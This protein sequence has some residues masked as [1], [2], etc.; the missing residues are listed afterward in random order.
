MKYSHCLLT[1][2]LVSSTLHLAF[3]QLTVTYPIENSVFQRDLNNQATVYVAGY[4]SQALDAVEVKFTPIRQGWGQESNWMTLQGGLQKGHFS[5]NIGWSGGW[6]RLDLRGKSGGNV[7]GSAVVN[8]V[9]VGEVFLIA[10]QSNGQGRVGYGAQPASDERVIHADYDGTSG[11]NQPFPYPSFSTLQADDVISPR[12]KSS[13]LWGKLGDALSSRLNVPILFYNTAWDG[14]AVRAWKESINGIGWSVYDPSLSFEPA[15]MPYGNLRQVM[16]NYV[17]IT[18]LRA[19]LW[20]QGEAD[21]DVGTS[22]GSY[23][24]DLETLINQTRNEF[25]RNISWVIARESYTGRAGIGAAIV[26]A[27]NQII[28]NMGNIFPGPELDKVQVPRPDGYHFSDGGLLTAASEWNN[29]LSSDFFSRSVPYPS[30]APISVFTTC[31]HNSITIHTEGAYRDFKWNT[32]SNNS[33]LNAGEGVYQVSAYDAEGNYRFSPKVRIP[34]ASELSIEQPTVTSVGKAEVCLGGSLTLVSSSDRNPVWSTG[35]TGK[36]V[37]ISAPGNYQV[38]IEN[39]Y[40]C[41]TTSADFTV[42]KS[43]KTLPAPPVVTAD[44]ATE[45]CAGEE[46]TL[47]SNTGNNTF[48]SNGVNN[49]SATKVGSN[50]QFFARTRDSEGCF[51]ENSNSIAVKVNALPAKPTISTD[52]TPEFCDGEE[53]TLKSSYEQGNTWSDNST[54]QQVVIKK[55]G[56]YKVSV[57][58]AKGCKNT[59]DALRVTVNA[60]PATPT[61]TSLRPTTFCQGDYSTLSATAED[62][63]IWNT[64]SNNRQINVNQNGDY[65]VQTK[66]DKGCFSKNSNIIS[67]TVNPL[68]EKPAIN[69]VGNATFCANSQVVLEAPDSKSYLWNNGNSARSLTITTAGSFYVQTINE[70][71]CYSPQSNAVQTRILPIP[72]PPTITAG[73][74][75]E[76]CDY[77]NVELRAGGP[78]PVIWSTSATTANVKVNQSGNYTART[79]AENGCFSNPSNMIKVT[80]QVTPPTPVIEKIGVYSVLVQN[81]L[82]GSSFNWQ[83]DS[84]PVPETTDGS[85]RISKTGQYR[86]Q[87]FIK[88]SDQLTCLSAYSEAIQF[89]FVPGAPQVNV[90]PNPNRGRTVKVETSQEISRAVV[91]IVSMQGIEMARYQFDK[92]LVPIELTL[93]PGLSGIYIIRIQAP[94][95]KASE[96]LIVA[97]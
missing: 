76:I 90:F 24:A 86:A 32:G 82:S 95:F 21:N 62:V 30:K 26:N 83:I 17:A 14:S 67:I 25:N 97:N 33:S 96:K 16:L 93:P 4:F 7:V 71:G 61:I 94:D 68:P 43:A 8:K 38:S 80:A 34:P 50:G 18:G 70:F 72:S 29:Y 35:Q 15:G 74:P 64:G 85:I 40:G 49:Q 42:E 92:I 55:S 81:N 87:S 39:M 60:L 31:E 65:W 88:Y 1:A 89:V 75:T 9:G 73:G 3:G 59:S 12:G 51:S 47:S 46:I 6:Y 22:Q 23:Y 13:W 11:P 79:I 63:Y 27:Q 44:R 19:I 57:T 41:R 28:Q 10:G 66:N 54:G 5:G 78:A 84:Q 36:Q 2:L 91:T 58:D 56:E 53:V 69:I 48:W 45:I 37:Q 20:M 52:R 77:G